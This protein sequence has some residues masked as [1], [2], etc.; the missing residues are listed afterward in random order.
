[1]SDADAETV[2]CQ[3]C[4]RW[5]GRVRIVDDVILCRV[6]ADEAVGYEQAG[7]NP[8]RMIDDYEYVSV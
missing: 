2:W 6:C 1:M 4:G 5:P 8:R 3:A 7:D